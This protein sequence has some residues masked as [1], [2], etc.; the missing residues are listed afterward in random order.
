MLSGPL[1][2][3]L[4]CGGRSSRFG[5]N[6]A[7]ASIGAV[8]LIQRVVEQLK[9][10]S[11]P[12][13]LITHPSETYSFLKLP[14]VLDTEPF[15]GP[16]IALANAFEK[17]AYEEIL[18][19]ACDIPSLNLKLVQELSGRDRSSDAC[20]VRDEAGPQYLLARYSRRLLNPLKNF[21]DRGGNSF[22][23]FFLHHPES[24]LFL[25]SEEKVFNLNTQKEL[26]EFECSAT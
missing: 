16:L 19:V 2:I 17:T 15:A 6:K 26:E 11:Y 7:L 25:D 24:I 8:S 1:G 13:F 9:L 18:L 14:V 21:I 23:E 3:G 22:K 12:I 10:L 4:L 5:S 20:V